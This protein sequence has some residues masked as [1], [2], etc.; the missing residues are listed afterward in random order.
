MQDSHHLEIFFIHTGLSCGAIQFRFVQSIDRSVAIVIL[1]CSAF[2]HVPYI[3]YAGDRGCV[4][5]SRK[6]CY[7]GRSHGMVIYHG[8]DFT[9]AGQLLFCKVRWP[10]I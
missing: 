4:V 8:P 6:Q 1:S 9:L 5:L 10:S 2:V 3:V 7:T